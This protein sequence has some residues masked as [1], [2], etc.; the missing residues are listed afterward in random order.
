[1]KIKSWIPTV[2]ALAG[3]MF[4]I[5]SA[6]SF[7]EFILY[8]VKRPSIEDS[9]MGYILMMSLYFNFKHWYEEE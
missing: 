8:G 2:L 7:M 3:I 1:M 4:F 6:W 5:D 9:I